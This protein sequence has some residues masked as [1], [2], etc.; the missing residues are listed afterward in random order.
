VLSIGAASVVK[1]DQLAAGSI[2]ADVPGRDALC[3]HT[4]TEDV[5]F[6]VRKNLLKTP[7][8]V[9]RKPIE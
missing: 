7:E 8:F 4:G 2:L 9:A 3:R 6:R 1:H 5:L